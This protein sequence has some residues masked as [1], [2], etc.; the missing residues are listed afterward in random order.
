MSKLLQYAKANKRVLISGPPGCAKTARVAEVAAAT[1]RELVTLRT[2]LLER[3]DV[4]GAMVPDLEAGVTRVLPLDVLHH[5]QTA[6]SPGMLFLDDLGQADIDVQS[7]L[8]KLFD[9]GVLSPHILIWGATNRP[10][11]AAGARRLHEALRSRFG[12]KWAIPTPG[13]EDTPDG[14][15]MLGTW[16]DEVA[17]WCKWAMDHGAP[18]EVVAWHR[19][20]SGRTLYAWQPSADPSIAM[21]DYRAWEDVIDLWN[22]GL[23]DLSDMASVVGKP[24]AAEFLAF[25]QLAHELPTPDQVWMDPAGAPVPQDAAALYLVATMLGAAVEPRFADAAVQYM[26]RLPREAPNGRVYSALLARDMDARLGASL[27]GFPRWVAWFTEN[28]ELFASSA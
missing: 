26:A 24:V 10:G 6:T 19:S 11:D 3:V 21:P 18:A 25:A 5:L 14:P 4:A 17:G 7:A 23:R 1:G 20:T 13:S 15:A 12:P 27:S 28:Q 22:S 8:M 16:A 2:S 9:P